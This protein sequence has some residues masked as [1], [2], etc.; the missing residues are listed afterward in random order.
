[1]DG[2]FIHNGLSFRIRAKAK[3]KEGEIQVILTQAMGVG[4]RAEK[5]DLPA[6]LP[7]TWQDSYGKTRS[8]D[9]INNFG[10]KKIGKPDFEQDEVPESYEI[11]LDQA[12]GK[13][14]LYYDARDRQVKPFSQGDLGQPEGQPGKISAR[15][16]LG[17]PPIG[18]G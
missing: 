1:M 18:T 8:V 10:I 14:L 6:D 16:K 12:E 9:W 5:K 13:T 4:Y 15:L 7:T 3:S 17:D 2:H 11:I